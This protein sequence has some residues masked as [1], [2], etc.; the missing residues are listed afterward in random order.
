MIEPASKEMSVRRQCELLGLSPSSY[1][2]RA[3]PVAALDL[4][5]MRLL[6]EQFTRTP[7]YGVE[8]MTWW[9]HTQGHEV[10]VKRVR[11]LLRLMGLMAVYPK[12]RLSVPGT[13]AT[14][15]VYLLGG[16]EVSA[17]DQAWA[18]DITYIRLRH[19]FC[20]LCAI[21]DWFSRHVVA[22]SLSGNLEAAFCIEALDMALGTG[23]KPWCLNSDQG[24]PFTCQEFVGRLLDNGIKPSWDGRGRWIDNVFVERLWRTVKYESVYLHDWNTVP[25]A[26]RGLGD[27]F[28]FIQPPAPAF[29]AGQPV[30]DILNSAGKTRGVRENR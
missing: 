14:H 23:R 28:A 21:L 8:R 29:R 16:M 30:S 26:R 6:D 3:A 4:E 27:Y 9:L 13:V 1:Y 19:G 2:H 12:P 11:R 15:Y 17:P 18:T 22:W 5:Q 25:E 7:F 10:N 24:S 20:Y